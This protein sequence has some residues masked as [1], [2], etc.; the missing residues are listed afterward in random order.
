MLTTHIPI[1]RAGPAVGPATSRSAMKYDRVVRL[2]LCA[3]LFVGCHSKPKVVLRPLETGTFGK[4]KIET[5]ASGGHVVKLTYEVDERGEAA[6]RKLVESYR[7]RYLI[8]KLEDAMTITGW[9]FDSTCGKSGLTL[10]VP[11]EATGEAL[12]RSG[13][14]LVR[15]PTDIEVTVV[16]K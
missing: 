2:I 14:V 1:G 6:N 15:N 3:L 12:R 5:C 10:R 16:G 8:P 4:Y 11:A 13:E 9:T 7:D